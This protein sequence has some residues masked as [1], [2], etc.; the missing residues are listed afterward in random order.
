M[1]KTPLI[2]EPY[3]VPF[4]NIAQHTPHVWCFFVDIGQTHFVRYA[5]NKERKMISG[6]YILQADKTYKYLLNYCFYNRIIF[7]KWKQELLLSIV[8]NISQY[9]IEK[10]QLYVRI[11]YNSSTIINIDQHI[12]IGHETPRC[13]VFVFRTTYALR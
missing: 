13:S 6:T 1:M 8:E 4:F 7:E 2:K 3:E 10:L 12:S 5:S 11:L 9:H